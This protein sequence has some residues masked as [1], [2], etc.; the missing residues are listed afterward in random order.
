MAHEDATLDFRFDIPESATTSATTDDGA[1][2]APGGGMLA[3]GEYGMPNPQ[4]IP[5]LAYIDAAEKPAEERLSILLEQMATQRPILMG[6]LALCEDATPT[7][8]VY[9]EVKA[10]QKNRSSVFAPENLCE[11]LERAGALERVD[12]NGDLL[13]LDESEPITI[14]EDDMEYI[15]PNPPE[16]AFWK[17]TETGL[18]LVAND[19][20][21][22]RLHGLLEEDGSYAPIYR[23][24]LS[25][26]SNATGM[27]TQEIG[28]HVDGDPL[29]QSPRFYAT[30]FIDRLERAGGIE[31]RQAWTITEE[32]AS[33]LDELNTDH[34]EI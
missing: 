17:T 19:D 18:R 6:I 25:L 7:D 10:Q 24:I 21:L 33:L 1:L 5:S 26:C 16:A 2:S 22:E 20:P 31:W 12:E 29:L 27:T 8:D 14:A 15:A 13:R 28:K 11:L 30:K 23:Q 32:G 9:R 4:G 3:D 34:S